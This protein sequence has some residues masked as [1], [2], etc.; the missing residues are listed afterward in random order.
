[1]SRKTQDF[2]VFSCVRV[3]FNFQGAAIAFVYVQR[4]LFPVFS[5][6][7]LVA[8]FRTVCAHEVAEPFHELAYGE[9]VFVK[10]RRSF[11]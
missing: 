1:M 4:K 5:S 2:A 11:L 10:H 7:N 8:S 6:P 3:L 9:I